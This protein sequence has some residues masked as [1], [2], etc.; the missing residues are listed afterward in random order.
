MSSTT[1]YLSANEL[2]ELVDCKPNQRTR[3]VTWLRERKWKFE[4]GSTGLPRVARAYH[5]RMMGIIDEP[6]RQKY[7]DEP[8]LKAFAH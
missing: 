3:M 6:K 2:A 8:N 1:G 4:V 7:A 5:D